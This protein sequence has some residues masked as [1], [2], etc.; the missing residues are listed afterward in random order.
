MKT[1]HENIGYQRHE[2][3]EMKEQCQQRLKTC[4][5]I[6]I[7]RDLKSLIFKADLIIQSLDLLS[8]YGKV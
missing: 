4:K 7:K 2:L 8:K 5:Q 3:V 6:N 1:I